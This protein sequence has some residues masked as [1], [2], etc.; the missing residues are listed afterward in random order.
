MENRGQAAARQSYTEVDGQSCS[1]T[2]G[3]G[4]TESA[5]R[6]AANDGELAE[7][8]GARLECGANSTADRPAAAETFVE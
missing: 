1:Y 7:D 4:R 3:A 5:I 2:V 8:A 6:H